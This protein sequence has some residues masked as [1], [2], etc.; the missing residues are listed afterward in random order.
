MG[1]REGRREKERGGGRDEER[2]RG[3]G[4]REGGRAGGRETTYLDVQPPALGVD[5]YGGGPIFRHIRLQEVKVLRVAGVVAGRSAVGPA[6]D[7][8]VES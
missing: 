6:G 3:G 8:D 4:G 2:K 1:R 5:T 7:R